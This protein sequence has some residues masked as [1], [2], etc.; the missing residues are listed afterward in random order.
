MVINFSPLCTVNFILPSSSLR[1]VKRKLKP[2]LY[3]AR[4]RVAAVHPEDQPG[5]GRRSGRLGGEELWPHSEPDWKFLRAT[6]HLRP[7]SHF[8]HSPL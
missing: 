6:P 4:V 7:A 1:L 3:A 2:F 8:L 5:G